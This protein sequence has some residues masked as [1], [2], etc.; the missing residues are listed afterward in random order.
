MMPRVV[1]LGAH[2]PRDPTVAWQRFW[3]DVRTTGNGGDVLWDLDTQDEFGR[4]RGLLDEHFDRSLPIID[5]G[6]GNGRLT[7]WLAT[8]FPLAVGVDVAAT[9]IDRARAESGDQSG[10]EFVTVDSCEESAGPRLHDRYGDAN[11]F[12][13]G[14]LHVLDDPSRVATAITAHAI[15]GKSGGVFL[16]ETDFR[17]SGLAYL[18]HLGATARSIPR[19]LLRAIGGL[20]QPGHFGPVE[21]AASF[22]ADQWDIIIDGPTTI[23]TVP[24]RSADRPETIPGYVAVLKPRA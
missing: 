16:A 4:Y 22:P 9:A 8:M 10:L 11:V 6:C 13:R 20:P 3:H 14:V 5:V 19:P 23:R 21:R 15:V 2:V 1:A 17:G 12:F 24:M 7:R 18:E